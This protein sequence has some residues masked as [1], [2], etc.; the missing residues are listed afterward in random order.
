M[1]ESNGN[2]NAMF[3][4][5]GPGAT[6]GQDEGTV[7]HIEDV[8]GKPMYYG[9]ETPENPNGKPVTITVAGTYSRRYRRIED[10]IRRR[11]MKARKITGEKFY[12]EMIEKVVGCTIAWEGFAMGAQPVLLND[13][14]AEKLYKNFPWVLD[15]V[16]EAMAESERF[17]AKDSTS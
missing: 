7:V 4:L 16:V 13:H 14:N 11:P 12:D 15:Q 3:D 8:L 6:Q 1:S 5:D 2:G 9:E 10:Q 17:F